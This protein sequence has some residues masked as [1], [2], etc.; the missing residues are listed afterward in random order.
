MKAMLKIFIT[1]LAGAI[2]ASCAATSGTGGAGSSE[3][4]PE[5]G[6]QVSGIQGT[7]DSY[8]ARSTGG[9]GAYGSYG[10][11]SGQGL[12]APDASP[13]QRVVYFDFDSAEIRPEGRTVVE[14]NVRYLLSNPGLTTVLEGNTDERGTREYNVGLGERRADAVRRLMVAL[15]VSPQQIRAVSYGEERPAVAGHEEASYSQN[16][17][18]EIAY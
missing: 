7:A 18:V 1:L 6:T 4:V 15:G 3:A 13:M 11:Q 10:G 17:R 16:R 8:D 12:G 5:G 2:L 14:N 9:A